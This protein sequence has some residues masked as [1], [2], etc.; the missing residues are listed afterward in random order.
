MKY[1][2][3]I[4]KARWRFVSA[5]PLVDT[6]ESQ[7][8]RASPAAPQPDWCCRVEAAETLPSGKGRLVSQLPER[9]LYLDGGQLWLELLNRKDG[10]PVFCASYPVDGGAEVRLWGLASQYP[11]TA[12]MEHLWAAVDFPHH[13]LQK[14]VLT[15]HSAC[16]EA[17]GR[18]ILFLA[19]S[20]VGK[21]T[22]AK[23]W[24]DLRGARQ[25]NGDKTGITC[26]GGQITAC[27][28]PFCGTSGICANFEL[29]VRAVVLLR[30]GKENAV[31]QLTGA[32]ALRAVLENC[33]G[34]RAVPGCTEKLLDILARVLEQV[35]V[36][37][38]AC[39]PDERAVIALENQLRKDG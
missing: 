37:S 2:Y 39:T 34:H 1:D 5:Y 3:L 23:L 9:R 15:L 24:Q 6:P 10:Q 30:Q 12:R 11:Y 36:Y 28:L 14:G 32:A 33:F 8:F 16:I 25:L 35:P 26:R 17:D 20:G 7:I 4:S 38:L 27:G 13:L 29:P 31:S 19:P 21:S 18:A 22:Q